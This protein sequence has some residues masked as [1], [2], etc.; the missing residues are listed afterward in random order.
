M[1]LEVGYVVFLVVSFFSVL[2]LVVFFY[3][4]NREVFGRGWRDG[5]ARF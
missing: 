3:G 5:V 1:I 2:G 4:L